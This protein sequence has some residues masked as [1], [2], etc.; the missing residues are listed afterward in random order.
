[1]AENI[2][3][4]CAEYAQKMA[5]GVGEE[6]TI[7]KS[8]GVL[9]EDGLYAFYLYTLSLEKRKKYA[10]KARCIIDNSSDLLSTFSLIQRGKVTPMNVQEVIA[11]L[12]KELDELIWAKEILERTLVYA[13][14]HAKAL[15]GKS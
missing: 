2:D 14:Y 9:Q 12:T 6:D 8:L 15:G 5:Q 13:R 3:F 10:D 1:M 7:G 4:Q 11:P